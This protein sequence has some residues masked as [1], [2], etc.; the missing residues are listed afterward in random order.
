MILAVIMNKYPTQCYLPKTVKKIVS[1][2]AT[3]MKSDRKLELFGTPQSA[4][5]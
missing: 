5:T 4:T 1:G 2:S 3:A